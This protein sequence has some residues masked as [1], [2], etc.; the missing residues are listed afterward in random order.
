MGGRLSGED[1]HQYMQEFSEKFLNGKIRF[2]TEVNKIRR[3]STGLWLLDTINKSTGSQEILRF[4]RIVLCTGVCNPCFLGSMSVSDL[5]KNHKGCS[6]PY[7]DPNLSPSVAEQAQFKGPVIHSMH[8]NSQI[9]TIL[10]TVEPMQPGLENESPSIVIIGGGKY[11]QECVVLIMRCTHAC[12]NI[13]HL[14]YCCL[15]SQRR[16]KSLSRL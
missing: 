2:D 6:T 8:F 9:K 15:F 14:Q 5:F 16:T 4:S 3:D 7:F 13:F 11:A 12:G 10:S 1:M